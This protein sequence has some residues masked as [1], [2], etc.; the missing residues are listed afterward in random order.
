[1]RLCAFVLIKNAV[2]VKG[3]AASET[4]VHWSHLQIAPA[5]VIFLESCSEGAGGDSADVTIRMHQRGQ[6]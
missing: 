5:L 4:E 1:M 6:R 3:L 2:E